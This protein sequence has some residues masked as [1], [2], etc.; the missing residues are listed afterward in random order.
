MT[1]EIQIAATAILASVL[2]GVY[3]YLRE[4][5]LRLLAEARLQLAKVATAANRLMLDGETKAGDLFHD[6]V[7]DCMLT[8]QFATRFNLR[9]HL[10]KPAP[11]EDAEFRKKLDSEIRAHKHKARLM[12]EFMFSCM[13]AFSYSHP[14]KFICFILWVVFLNRGLAV[15]GL[16]IQGKQSL[17]STIARLKRDVAEWGVV[18]GR[19]PHQPA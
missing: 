5:R 14:F 19:H 6:H 1:T 11:Q 15:F 16:M 8:A 18:I 10:F 4:R 12:T 13:K 3:L 2:P 17:K 7:C 9:W